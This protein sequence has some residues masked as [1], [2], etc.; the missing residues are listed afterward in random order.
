MNNKTKKN[1]IRINNTHKMKN[2]RTANKR[3][4]TIKNKKTAQQQEYGLKPFEKQY[5]KTHQD[6][7]KKGLVDKQLIEM[8]KRKF[9]P[10]DVKPTDDYYT[11]INYFWLNKKDD[12]SN[13]NYYVQ[14]DEF[15]TTQDKVYLQVLGIIKNYIKNN[16]KTTKGKLLR[17]VYNSFDKLYHHSTMKHL[18]TTLELYQSYQRDD[19]LLAYLTHININEIVSWGCPI[20]HSVEP[21]GLNRKNHVDYITCP[22]LSLYNTNLYY[23]NKVSK[24]D[25][26]YRTSIRKHFI[27]YVNDIFAHCIPDKTTGCNGEDVF[28]V[29][30][31]ILNAMDCY[32]PKIKEDQN[33][34]FYNRIYKDDALKT[35]GFDWDQFAKL[36]GYKETP[37]FFICDSPNYLKCICKLLKENWKT[38]K[39][40]SYWLYIFFRQIIRFDKKLSLIHYNFYSKFINGA[41]AQF[42]FKLLIL[43]G[44][45]FI[46]NKL[47]TI[48]Y[49]ELYRDE[50]IINYTKTMGYDMI[51]VFK[52]IIKRNK[53]LQ[54]KTKESALQKL[55][56]LSLDIGNIGELVD[57]PL[58]E[59]T[60]DDAWGNLLKVLNWR[61]KLFIYTSSNT[62]EH[63]TRDDKIL[64][65]IPSVDWSA[66]QFKLIGRQAYIVNAMYTPS[67]NNIYIPLGYL[68]KPF[69]DLDERGIEYNL[70][71]IGYT[72]CHEMSHALDD[73]GSKYDYKGNLNN[74]WSNKDAEIFRKKQKDIIKQYEVFA[75]YDGIKYDA[76]SSIGEDLADISG[77][78]ICEEYLRDFQD[79]NQDIV[80]VR[81]LSF[82][83]FYVYFAM[84]QRQKIYKGAIKAQLKT[85]P[86][87]PDKYRV[88]VP[89]SRL[90]L[91]RNL[92]NIKKG[93]KMYWWNTDTI[94]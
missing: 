53:W 19:N 81:N 67:L 76:E 41:P 1:R 46:F 17:N 64:G 16:R 58:L 18:N 94:W 54:P 27:K 91:F 47:I 45:S 28:D 73:F 48:K 66:Y 25:E 51:E 52:R 63:T 8:F 57:D 24:E 7:I 4:I 37:S 3:P 30:V 11:Y 34:T 74:L 35:Y 42:P 83:A 2:K 77:L 15:R 43:F 72:L 55:N 93:D 88:N 60:E 6:V 22:Q 50:Q 31:E 65:N 82:Q 70:S 61:R 23:N 84:E 44:T 78:A 40:K 62:N 5:E 33:G 29:E 49:N 39:W 36:L 92:Y 87:P 71:H 12:T 90:E 38:P 85:N 89:L 75:S 13:K 20:V 69:V 26:E 86:H 14:I 68:Q 9:L 59:Y 10:S 32:S 56:H 21:D 79:K 80:P